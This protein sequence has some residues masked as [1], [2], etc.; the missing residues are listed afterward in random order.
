[1]KKKIYNHAFLEMKFA[2]GCGTKCICICYF[3]AKH[4]F[5]VSLH[6]KKL[7]KSAVTCLDWHPNNS[8]IACGGTDYKCRVFWAHVEAVDGPEPE[9][10]NWITTKTECLQEY[11]SQSS[12]WVYSVSFNLSGNRLAW[13]G[14]DST[15]YVVDADRSVKEYVI[16]NKILKK[17]LTFL[18]I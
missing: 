18:F 5:W 6:V 8:I 12:G 9:N 15:I 13:V 10:K 16:K 7:L 1:M 3:E 11:G 2:V 17:L 14:H 4:L